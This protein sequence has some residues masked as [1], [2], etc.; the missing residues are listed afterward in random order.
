MRTIGRGDGHGQ[1]QRTGIR[2]ERVDLSL[3]LDLDL[4]PIMV[5]PQMDL[6]QPRNAVALQPDL[7][8]DADRRELRPPIPAELAGRLADVRAAGDGLRDTGQVADRLFLRR[9]IYGRRKLDPQLVP[10]RHE[11]RLHVPPV[12]PE[13]VC[14][15]A[16]HMTVEGHGRQGIQPVANQPDVRLAQKSA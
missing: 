1:R 10:F 11:Q 2:P 3:N 6:R 12:L 13:H 8:P 16:E 14:G 5:L 7:F 9:I 15:A 4:S